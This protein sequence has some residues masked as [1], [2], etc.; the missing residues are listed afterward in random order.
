[1]SKSEYSE[2]E[3]EMFEALELGDLPQLLSV[4]PMYRIAVE[5]TFLS[6]KEGPH[7]DSLRRCVEALNNIG[8]FRRTPEF[9]ALIVLEGEGSDG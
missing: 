6:A 1:M 7:V 9:D 2:R 3:L 4:V 5:R 8:P